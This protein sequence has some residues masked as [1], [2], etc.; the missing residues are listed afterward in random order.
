MKNGERKPTWL[1]DEKPPILMGDKGKK[2][3][4][5]LKNSLEAKQKRT[6]ITQ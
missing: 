4:N 6:E 5:L 2:L 1:L 3:K